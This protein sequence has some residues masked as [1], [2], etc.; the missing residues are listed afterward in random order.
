M[1]TLKDLPNEVIKEEIFARSNINIEKQI[2]LK[3]TFCLKTGQTKTEFDVILQGEKYKYNNLL[4][5]I[6]AYNQE[7]H[8]KAKEISLLEKEGNELNK[9]ALSLLEKNN[10]EANLLHFSSN[11]DNL[12]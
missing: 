3:L 11:F 5:A 7:N 6:A 12:T 10:P 2:I 4:F 8:E 1:I 9:K